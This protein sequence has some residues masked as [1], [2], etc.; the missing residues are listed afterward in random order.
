VKSI[1]ARARFAPVLL[2]ALALASF[3]AAAQH[4]VALKLE[5]AQLQNKAMRLP[6]LAERIAKLYLQIGQKLAAT[7]TSRNLAA[8]IGEFDAGLKELVAQAPTPEIRENYQLLGLLWVEYKALAQKPPDRDGAHALAEQNEEVVWIAAKGAQLIQ[9]YARAQATELVRAAG[10]VRVLSQRIA[11]LYL[12]RH[13]GVRTE[14]IAAELKAA[15]GQ[16][17]KAMA[18]LVEA[19]QNTPEIR[20]ELQLAEN[21]YVFLGQ[22]VERLNTGKDVAR[23]LEFVAKTCDNLIEVMDRAT[24]LYE[25]VRG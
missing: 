22:A 23:E 5:F 20:A 24:R 6:M 13:W 10:E 21:Q 19:P 1:V 9:D 15:D 12:L 7:R 14:G 2:V 8:A 4:K 25:G 17:R 11:K 3:P 18:S 16:F